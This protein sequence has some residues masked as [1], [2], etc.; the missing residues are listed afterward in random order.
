MPDEPKITQAEKTK[1][2]V[3]KLANEVLPNPNANFA[4]TSTPEHSPGT[5]TTTARGQPGRG[6]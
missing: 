3:R 5:A 2:I 1:K 4:S 6:G